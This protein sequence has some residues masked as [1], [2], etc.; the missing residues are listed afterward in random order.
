MKYSGATTANTLLPSSK[1]TDETGS[2]K[3]RALSPKSS[4][5]LTGSELF[6]SSRSSQQRLFTIEGELS[7]H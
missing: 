7:G 6:M 4:E 5:D 2:S 3:Q 1:S